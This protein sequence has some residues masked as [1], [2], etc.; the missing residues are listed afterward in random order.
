MYALIISVQGNSDIIE[1]VE[2][3]FLKDHN[4]AIDYLSQWDYGA[5]SEYYLVEN[6]ERLR[7]HDYYAKGEYILE[8]LPAME[9]YAL[10][11]R[12]E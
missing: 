1:D 4:A 11:R 12:V 7:F 10:Y 8:A 3:L 9:W 2:N 6:I 5:E